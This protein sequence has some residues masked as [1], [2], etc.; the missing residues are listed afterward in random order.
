MARLNGART[1]VVTRGE[2]I[3]KGVTVVV[4][5]VTG[6]QVVVKRHQ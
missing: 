2:Y 1:D 6:N 3:E 5:K 4:V